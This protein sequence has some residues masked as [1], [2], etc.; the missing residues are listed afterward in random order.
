[1]RKLIT[2]MAFLALLAGPSALAR[3]AGGV[4][5]PHARHH[6]HFVPLPPHHQPRRAS[7]PDGGI[8]PTAREKAVDRKINDIC[9]GC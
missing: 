4:R 7:S 3:D 8:E 1:M 9:R 6:H 2:G 5:K